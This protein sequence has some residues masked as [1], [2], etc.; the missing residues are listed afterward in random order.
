MTIVHFYLLFSAV[1]VL[2][3]DKFWPVFR[4]SYSWWL[5][6]VL[7]LAIFIALVILQFVVFVTMI[8]TTNM[9]KAPGKGERFFR[10]LIKHSLPIIFGLAKVKIKAEGLENVQGD[11]V[12]LFVCNHQYDFDPAIIYYCFPDANISFIGKK[13]IITEKTFFAKAM[14]RLCCLFIDREND[15]EAAKTVISAIKSLKDGKNSIGLFPEGYCSKDD[16]LLPLR[17]GSLKIATKSKVPVVVC[18]IDNTKA[19]LKQM[20]RK[21]TE[22]SFK[23]MDVI[24]PET[25][26]NMTTSDLG[27]IITAKFKEGLSEIRNK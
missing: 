11:E 12:K 7:I 27:E 10:F 3:S 4:Q 21:T 5:V 23:V 26:E 20:F 18:T 13:D 8:L 22:V 16:E 9:K 19:I 25:Y 24:P 1:A 15:R 6:P 2:I 14:H 17:N